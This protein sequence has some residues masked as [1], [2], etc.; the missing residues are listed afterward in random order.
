[1][2]IASK[3]LVTVL[4]PLVN[5]G[6]RTAHLRVHIAQRSSRATLNRGQGVVIGVL[7]EPCGTLER[8]D[9]PALPSTAVDDPFSGAGGTWRA[10]PQARIR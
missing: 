1:M 6:A 5:R 8:N 10:L 7:S 2:E 9:L 3:L 4:I